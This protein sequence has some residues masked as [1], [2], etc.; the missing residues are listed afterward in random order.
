M[1]R[2]AGRL[3]A[4]REARLEAVDGWEWGPRDAAWEDGFAHL[5]A[6][7][8]EHGHARVPNAHV[9]SDGY[10][11]GNW[12]ANQ[13]SNRNREKLSAEREARLE[14]VDGWVW[15]ARGGS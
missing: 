3:S 2:K 1:D 15:V 13:R 7:A 4:E 10:K 6:Y 14:A 12:V 9:T 5:E 8:A 11:L